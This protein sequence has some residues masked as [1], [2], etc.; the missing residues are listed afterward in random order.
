MRKSTKTAL[1]CGVEAV[2]C[3]ALAVR[4]KKRRQTGGVVVCGVST[5]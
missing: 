2:A 3:I 4:F 1:G 5:L